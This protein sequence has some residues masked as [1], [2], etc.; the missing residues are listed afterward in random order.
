MASL[1]HIDLKN[2]CFRHHWSIADPKLFVLDAFIDIGRCF[3]PICLHIC[4]YFC[5]YVC[6]LDMHFDTHFNTHFNTHLY[7]LSM[8][9][10]VDQQDVITYHNDH[11]SHFLSSLE[12]DKRHDLR[13]CR[14]PKYMIEVQSIVVD[15]SLY[16]A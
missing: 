2:I 6:Q 11:I 4:Q 13:V 14:F 16:L 1:V 15:T 12:R 3:I 5:Q 10:L 8:M 7:T 9:S